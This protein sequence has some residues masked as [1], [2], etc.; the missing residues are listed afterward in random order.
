MLQFKESFRDEVVAYIQ[1]APT[2][3]FITVGG[4]VKLVKALMTLKGIEN[5]VPEEL[6]KRKTEAEKP[7]EKK[8]GSSDVKS[9]PDK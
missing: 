9:T 5:D 7:E 2:P 6:D 8:E 4:A 3:A 1:N